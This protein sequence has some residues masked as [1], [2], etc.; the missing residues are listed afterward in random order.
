MQRDMNEAK[1][2]GVDVYPDSQ[3]ELNILRGIQFIARVRA[4]VQWY[5]NVGYFV[6]LG[7]LGMIAVSHDEE[8]NFVIH[9]PKGE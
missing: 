3:T 9:L 2:I 1:D 5:S 8:G 7:H 4:V 6:R